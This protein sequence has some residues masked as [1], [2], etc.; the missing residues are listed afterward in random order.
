MAPP[1]TLLL[2]RPRPQGE[3]FA[4]E[5]GTLLPGRFRPVLA[6]VLEIS[7]L[8]GPIPLDGVTG[9]LFTSANGV[10]Q[11]AART[12]RRDLP[13]Y[14]VGEI[15]AEAAR[16]A[17]MQASSA[18]GDVHDLAA[19]VRARLQPGAGSLLHIRGRH[20]AGSLTSM[21]AAD[22]FATR[23][24][25]IYDQRPCLIAGE[26]RALLDAGTADVVAHFSPRSARIFADQ[27][28]REGWP[29]SRTTSVA[30]SAAADA[31]LTQAGFGRRLVATAPTRD[32]IVARLTQA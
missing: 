4:A 21:L 13:A 25:E 3:A 26:G 15:T 17:G 14:C 20:A 8:P 29:L 10:A 18:D 5:I 32:A 2:T 1:R 19:L 16:Q 31:A 22:G 27:A 23:A 28:A 6:P 30:L 12:P 9:L 11:F 24:A 7:P